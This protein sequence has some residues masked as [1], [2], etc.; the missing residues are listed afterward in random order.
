ME[1][2]KEEVEEEE[3]KH[4]IIGGDFNARTGNKEGPVETTDERGEKSRKLKDK[5]INRDG[6]IMLREIGDRGWTIN[7]S[8]GKEGEW[9][10]ITEAGASVIDYVVTNEK[11]LEEVIK[12]E[13]GNRTESDHVPLEVE[14]EGKEENRKKSE[15]ITREKCIWIR[16]GVEY[17]HSKCEGWNA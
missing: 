14:I 3:E 7:G 2:I 16:E 15:I 11:A 5:V 6:E 9:T 1:T 4:L 10:F 12:V 8:R 17:Y 13:E